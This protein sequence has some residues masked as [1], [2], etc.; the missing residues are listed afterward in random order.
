MSLVFFRFHTHF[1]F[2][3]YSYL[4]I[5]ALTVRMGSEEGPKEM[6]FFKII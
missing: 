5:A 1:C 4:A 2:L 3:Q 6:S